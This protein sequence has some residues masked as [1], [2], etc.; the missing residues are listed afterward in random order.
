MDFLSL[1]KRRFSVRKY[2]DKPI[3][4]DVL[5]RVLEAGR[6][7]PSAVNFQP[8]KFV[9]IDEPGMLEKVFA[10]YKRDWIRSA[11]V[12]I[13]VC[14]DHTRS[15]HR[16]DGKDHADIDIAITVDHMTLAAVEEGLGTC[17]VCN[18]NSMDLAKVLNLPKGTEAAVML[19][20][21]Y[22]AE[23]GDPDRHTEKRK[24]LEEITVY[25]GF[26]LK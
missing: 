3:P 22:P 18:F 12:V 19:P 4:R 5:E 8:W 7:A 20:L 21:G 2:T 16:A 6:M 10:T 25:N 9:V 26:P 14:G 23:E 17:W 11:P 13:V 24:P 15:W 1:A